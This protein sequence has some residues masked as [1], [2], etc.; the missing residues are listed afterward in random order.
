MLSIRHLNAPSTRMISR[1]FPVLCFLSDNNRSLDLCSQYWSLA[2]N[3]TWNEKVTA[4]QQESGLSQRDLLAL[5]GESCRSYVHGIV[6]CNCGARPEISALQQFAAVIR[7]FVSKGHL[8]RC[9]ACTKA[10]YAQQ[11]AKAAAEEERRQAQLTKWLA[12]IRGQMAPVDYRT[13]GYT[14]AFFLYVVLLAAGERWQGRDIKF[15]PAQAPNLAPTAEMAT[16][17]YMRLYK[18]G[19]IA[20]SSSSS[21]RVFDDV[22]EAPDEFN[23][24]PLEAS[25][26]LAAP[27]DGMPIEGILVLLENVL[28]HR[29]PASIA[30][31]WTMVAEAECERYFGELCERYRFSKEAV[32]SK[33]VAESIRYCLERVS[34]PQV[35]N[36]L[37]CTM[38]EIAA[39][40]Q[41]G[42]Y[43]RPHVYNM[44]AGNI[45]RDIDRK[46]ANNYA[47]RPWSRLRQEKEPVITGVLFDKIL[48]KGDFA[49]ETV[50]GKNVVTFLE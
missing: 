15:L 30:D 17:I 35:W 31:I 44:V 7:S 19:I 6:C 11:M 48:G 9:H 32:F 40:V 42:K 3:G 27:A 2:A 23:F 26:T 37:W 16:A 45:R 49:F 34:L 28:D 8:Y 12:T 43:I 39:L 4:L 47:I 41:E 1:P 46:L 5:V 33:K 36:I 38:R 18:A 25:W 13:L 29:V 50:N 14:E 21:P 20:P 24:S 22:G 10:E